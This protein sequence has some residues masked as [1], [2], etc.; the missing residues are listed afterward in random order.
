[1][2]DFGIYFDSNGYIPYKAQKCF[3]KAMK[4]S[5]LPIFVKKKIGSAP[6]GTSWISCLKIYQLPVKNVLDDI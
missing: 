1:M 3:P 5:D 6:L 2:S 4:L